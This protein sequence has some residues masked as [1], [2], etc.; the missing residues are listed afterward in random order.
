MIHIVGTT[1]SDLDLVQNFIE[2][3]ELP[4]EVFIKNTREETARFI[5]SSYL[6]LY[7]DKLVGILL[8]QDGYIDTIV[9]TKKGVGSMLLSI[10]DGEELRTNIS[11]INIASQDL[12]KKFGF[13]DKG[14]IMLEGEK[15]RRYTNTL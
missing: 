2:A 7:E 6:A 12:F 10:L 9:S 3:V 14:G 4:R 8:I 13:T 15:R 1:E 11:P 5:N